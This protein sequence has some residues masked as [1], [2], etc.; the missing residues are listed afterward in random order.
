MFRFLE[1]N[2]ISIIE[3]SPTADRRSRDVAEKEGLNWKV[4]IEY[5]RRE[6][7]LHLFYQAA[8]NA[9]PAITTGTIEVQANGNTV[10]ARIT[11]KQWYDFLAHTGYD[12]VVNVATLGIINDIR[13]IRIFIY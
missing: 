7:K 1:T 12:I 11:R 2:A 13:D 5:L 8:G 6:Q 4:R 10:S 9:A 3:S